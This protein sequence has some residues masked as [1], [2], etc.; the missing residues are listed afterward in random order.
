[1]IDHVLHLLRCQLRGLLRSD[2]RLPGT[3]DPAKDATGQSCRH[4]GPERADELI[5]NARLLCSIGLGK[6][7]RNHGADRGRLVGCEGSRQTFGQHIAGGALS[8]LAEWLRA[9]PVVEGLCERIQESHGDS[10]CLRATALFTR[11]AGAK[12]AARTVPGAVLFAT[13]ALRSRHPLSE[14]PCPSR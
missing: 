14:R 2:L 13:S 3:H 11:S 1:M 8:D 10:F 7:L 5:E 9:I 4:A 12:I 6:Q